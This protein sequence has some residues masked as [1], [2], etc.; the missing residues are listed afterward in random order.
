MTNRTEPESFGL[1][2]RTIIE[3]IGPGVMAIVINRKSRIIM[4]DARRIVA[5]AAKIT[6]TKP[7]TKVVLKTT[8]PVCSKTMQYLQERG[9]GVVRV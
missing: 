2:Q 7:G 6:K 4:A 9:I 8:A 5:N 3:N 1:Q